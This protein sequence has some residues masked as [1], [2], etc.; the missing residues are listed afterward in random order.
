MVRAPFGI[1]HVHQAETGPVTQRPLEVVEQRPVRV[2]DHRCAGPMASP[3]ALTCARRYRMRPTSCTRPSCVG[4]SPEIAPFSVIIS[5]T[6]GSRGAAGS[7]GRA[8]HPA[9][10]RC[11][12]RCAW[13][14][15]R[16][17]PPARGT[18]APARLGGRHHPPG[19]E[20]DAE[21]VAAPADRRLV[22]IPDEVERMPDRR[23]PVLA[24]VG[25]VAVA[26]ERL[27]E[28]AVDVAVRAEGGRG[29]RLAV[30]GRVARQQ[31]QRRA[32]LAVAERR[33]AS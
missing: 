19:V 29:I 26:E 30:G 4:L 15:R 33:S 12:R 21:E 25:R 6:P 22:A 11:P 20:V 2:A 31:V 8:A 28:P 3:I 27:K 13:G 32:E 18:A 1:V 14:C 24:H 5:G 23:L 10:P 7:A 16:G 9:P 17:P